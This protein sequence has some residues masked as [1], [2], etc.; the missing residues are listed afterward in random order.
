MKNILKIIIINITLLFSI[1]CASQNSNYLTYDEYTGIKINGISLLNISSTKGDQNAMNT[2]FNRK[3][4]YE[5]LTIPDYYKRIT[6]TDLNIQF[7]KASNE[8]GIDYELDYLKILSSNV[9]I[10]IKGHSF[11]LGDSGTDLQNYFLKNPNSGDFVFEINPNN[12]IVFGT[13]ENYFF[14]EIKNNV[15]TSIMFVIND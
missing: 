8:L 10:E 15:I 11:K 3:F 5:S 9:T 12:N 2:L 6:D 1:S 4:Q 14:I 13:S 7:L